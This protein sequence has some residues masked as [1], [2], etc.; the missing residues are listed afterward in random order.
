MKRTSAPE[1]RSTCQLTGEIVERPS[2]L[3]EALDQADA[4]VEELATLR[5]RVKQLETD[6]AAAREGRN[7]AIA[8][9]SLGRMR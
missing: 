9:A 3:F 6:L 7:T 5:L 2:K 8:M 1:F 4:N